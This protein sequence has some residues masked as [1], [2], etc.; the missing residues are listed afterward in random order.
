M[1]FVEFVD[2]TQ[3]LHA[4]WPNAAANGAESTTQAA[5]QYPLWADIDAQE[6]TAALYALKAAGHRWPPTTPEVK[7]QIA[8]HRPDTEW[9]WWQH[10]VA[11]AI[12]RWRAAG[13]RP[14]TYVE[15]DNG[16]EVIVG[17]SSWEEDTDPR[18]VALIRLAGG[19]AWVAQ[20]WHDSFFRKDLR[21]LVASQTG[22]VAAIGQDDAR[23]MLQKT[24]EAAAQLPSEARA[25]LPS[26]P[27][28][29]QHAPSTPQHGHTKNLR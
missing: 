25:S 14:R 11:T 17:R 22:T 10:A 29:Q 9:A 27:A 18:V 6:A 4:L 16:V 12:E 21:E 23:K 2:I 13:P 5:L 7:A 8:G 26:L 20:H 15:H 3:V 1:N 24:H 28:P 19:I